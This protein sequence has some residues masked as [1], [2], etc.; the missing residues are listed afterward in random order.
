MARAGIYR[1]EA[2]CAREWE[3]RAEELD[4]GAVGHKSQPLNYEVIDFTDAHL[5]RTNNAAGAGAG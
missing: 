3:L 4:A 1:Q 5:Q 2:K